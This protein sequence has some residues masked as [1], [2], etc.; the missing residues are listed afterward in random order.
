MPVSAVFLDVGG[1]LHLPDPNIV[2]AALD[3]PVPDDHLARAHY[4]GTAA[5]DH[6]EEDDESVWRTYIRA[7]ASEIGQP[8]CADALFAAFDQPAMWNYQIPGAADALRQ[9]AA[10]GVDLAIVSN[11]DG[12]LE[13]RLRTE[14]LCQMGDGDGVC[15]AIVLDS[16]ACGFAKP[17]PRIFEL[18]LA[19]T[20]RAPHETVHIGDTVGADIVGARAAGIDAWHIDPHGF[21]ALT[22]HVH[23]ASLADAVDRLT[24]A[25]SGQ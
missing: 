23:L 11:S 20:G 24:A 22:D 1:V 15:V 18:A 12:T 8:Q 17:D 2:R 16:T 25:R 19:A 4:A 5:L 14:M 9:L 10:T 6:F 13:D 21:C 3:H 7:Y